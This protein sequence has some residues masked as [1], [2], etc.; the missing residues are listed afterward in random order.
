MWSRGERQSV[1]QMFDR[2]MRMENDI[3]N[4][5]ARVGGL[6]GRYT[7]MNKRMDAF[8]TRLDRELQWRRLALDEAECQEHEAAAA[9]PA[10]TTGCGP[11]PAL[12]P[13]SAP[14]RPMMLDDLPAMIASVPEEDV[15]N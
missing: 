14:E 11:L 9:A 3:G 1:D 8:D 4:M 7:H 5:Q 6:E 13:A 12:P 10:S 15:N 2:M